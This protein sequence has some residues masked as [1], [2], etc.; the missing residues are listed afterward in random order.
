MQGFF[1]DTSGLVK[2]F[3]RETGTGW[4]IG[5]CRP[6][7]GNTIY[8]AHITA[9]EVVSAL[10]RLT[11]GKKITAA[12]SAKAIGRFE[13]T[14]AGRYAFIEIRPAIVVEAM[15]LAKT[16][17]LRGYDAVQLAAALSA[18]RERLNIGASGLTF[19]SADN[20]LNNAAAAEGLAV[21]NPNNH[22]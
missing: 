1:F 6:S 9:V 4:T 17:G 13:R 15:R 19:I 20:K 3:N 16:Y 5:L 2:R 11:L 22:P 8:I 14:L 18:N 7:G 12:Q 10:T 21:D